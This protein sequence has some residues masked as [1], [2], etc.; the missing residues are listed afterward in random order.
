MIVAA[1]TDALILRQ[2]NVG[3]DLPAARAFLKEA[4]RH[5]TFFARFGFDCWFLKNCH[6]N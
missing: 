6:G 3:N 4:A 1:W 5:L 2:L